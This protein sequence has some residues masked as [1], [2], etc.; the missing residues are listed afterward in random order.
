[1]DNKKV[2][3]T[4]AAGHLGN[5]LVRELLEH[6]YEVRAMVLPNEDVSAL[7]G[8]DIELKLGNVLEPTSLDRV[9]KGI[10]YVFHMAGIVSIMPDEEQLVWN[11][12]VEG[13]RNV[14]K[15]ARQ[16]GVK[17]LVYT[18]SIHAFSRH[19]EGTIDEEVPFDPDNPVGAYDRTKAIA[20]LAV[21]QAIHEG[22]DAVI[23][24]P[25]G[26]IG[27]YD[28]RGSSMGELVNDL[29]RRRVHMLVE[30]AYD[31]VDVRDVAIGHRLALER[32]KTGQIY[33]LSGHQIQLFQLKE[34]VQK[35]NG[36]HTPTINVPIKLAKI[37]AVFATL[38]YRM[39]HKRP[40][41]TEYAL[42]TVCSNS[43]VSNAKAKKELGYNPRDVLNTLSDTIKWWQTNKRKTGAF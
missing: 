23:V 38:Y 7:V 12:N 4:G 16:A 40:K 15:A 31:F 27:P 3:V 36:L 21:K 14:L 10:D 18:S 41:F 42:E 39:A 19:W 9:M 32:G 11:V 28:Y 2:L 17:R 20:T 30:G 33:I 24:C 26:V 29:T 35:I 37:G 22:L 43:T 5:V 8:L 34:M 13:T 1:M 25:T 6:G